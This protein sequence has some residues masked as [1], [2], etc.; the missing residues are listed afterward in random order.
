MQLID[1][2]EAG[3]L[4]MRGLALHYVPDPV[5]PSSYSSF[6]RAYGNFG[7]TSAYDDFDSTH[8]RNF[9][10]FESI[11]PEECNNVEVGCSIQ[12]EL[13]TL[14]GFAKSLVFAMKGRGLSIMLYKSAESSLE[15]YLQVCGLEDR[16]RKLVDQSAP[17]AASESSLASE[18][19]KSGDYLGK[20]DALLQAIE[21]VKHP[22]FPATE[23]EC[24]DK[25]YVMRIA[26][27][28]GRE[29]VERL[30]EY[31]KDS[32]KRYLHSCGHEDNFKQI[33]SRFLTGQKVSS[34]PSLYNYVM[35]PEH[36][37]FGIMIVEMIEL[38][39]HLASIRRTRARNC[40]NLS[41]TKSFLKDVELGFSRGSYPDLINYAEKILKRHLSA[42]AKR[43]VSA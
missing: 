31:A 25:D 33:A 35:Y 41:R 27:V 36:S 28:F 43:G 39:D 29:Y 40:E 12:P 24:S 4:E 19:F 5:A 3:H 9:D 18:L 23:I 15:H 14:A 13:Y 34:A 26:D 22:R 42:C 10:H 32:F 16:Y 38:V 1:T 30:D 11:K 17:N 8:E 2:S 20:S 21:L 7:R 6:K 37:S